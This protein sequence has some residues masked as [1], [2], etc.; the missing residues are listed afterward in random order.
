MGILHYLFFRPRA[1]R[2]AEKLRD[3]LFEAVARGDERRLLSLAN[4]WNDLI[5]AEF[6]H[7]QTMPKALIGNRAYEAWYGKGLV[8]VAEFYRRCGVSALMDQL[9]GDGAENPLIRW[10]DTYTQATAL[11]DATQAEAVVALLEP[12]LAELT[13][14]GG[15]AVDM[16]QPRCLGL[17]GAA[18]HQLGH[19]ARAR[20]DT[21]AALRMCQELGDAE[22]LA[23]YT[24]NLEM[25]EQG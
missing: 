10:R 13:T 6:K 12:I 9:I 14:S 1:P 24:R 5:R 18:Y 8:G 22:G 15:S 21:L 11:L 20:T 19:Q 7:W 16:Y 2:S 23:T 4:T 17:R 3:Q 25:I